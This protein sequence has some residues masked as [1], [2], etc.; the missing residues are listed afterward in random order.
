MSVLITAF[1]GLDVSDGDQVAAFGKDGA[2]VGVGTVDHRQSADGGRPV[3]GLAVWG[4][5]RFSEEIDGLR[6]GE[7]FTLRW[8]DADQGVDVNLA[9]VSFQRG[10]S[11][12]YAR[13]GFIVVETAAEASIPVEFHLAQNYPNPFNSSTRLTFTL[14]QASLVSLSVSDMSGRLV[15]VIVSGQLPAGRHICSW[16]ARELPTGVYVFTLKADGAKLQTKGSLIK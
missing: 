6:D 15:D 12:V 2:L 13:D 16:E 4:D 11:L 1:N 9:P 5:D 8:W 10:G 3:C 14:P 7:R